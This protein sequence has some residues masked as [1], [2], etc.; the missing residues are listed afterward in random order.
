[1]LEHCIKVV[2]DIG[3]DISALVGSIAVDIDL[4]AESDEANLAV[5]CLFLHLIQLS[6]YGGF[7]ALKS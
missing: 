5:R 2:H 6:F 4:G 3:R 7:H 1:M